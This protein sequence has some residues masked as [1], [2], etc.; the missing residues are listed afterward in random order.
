[1]AEN[2][3]TAQRRSIP[4]AT[5]RRPRPPDT[6]TALQAERELL[7]MGALPP[8]A[9]IARLGT[10]DKGFSSAQVEERLARFGPNEVEHARRVG[11]FGEILQRSKNPCWSSSC[12]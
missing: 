2:L 12:W 10:T 6:A 11:F 4:A 8:E 9:V 1:V 5:T 7:E 3:N